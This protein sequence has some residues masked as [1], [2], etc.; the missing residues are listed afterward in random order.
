MMKRK[1]LFC[2]YLI[3]WFRGQLEVSEMANNR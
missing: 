2:I 3:F 1:A